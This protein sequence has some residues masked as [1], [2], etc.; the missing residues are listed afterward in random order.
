MFFLLINILGIS[1]SAQ[2]TVTEYDYTVHIGAFFKPK[3]NDF[4]RIQPLGFMY[5]EAAEQNLTRIYLGR[6][7]NETIAYK[8]LGQVKNGGY[9]DAFVTRK[10]INPNTEIYSI[11]LGSENLNTPIN[12]SEYNL[13]LIHI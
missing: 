4:E 13:S 1:L 6:Y 2:N 7:P 8:T 12:W 11:Y 3:I 5:A 10:K 9:P